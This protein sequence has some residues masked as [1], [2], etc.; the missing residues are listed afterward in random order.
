VG[1]SLVYL[2]ILA[3]VVG[4]VAL[5]K[6]L[7][8]L[9]IRNRR[10]AAAVLSFGLAL[11][12]AGALWPVSLKQS[13]RGD[14]QI[15]R[16]LP[17]YHF[18]ELHSIRVYAPPERILG[19]LK[20]VTI[21]EIRFARTLLWIRGLPGRLLGSAGPREV[22]TRPF[23]DVSDSPHSLILA[24]TEREI[25][26]G[27]VGRFWKMTPGGP[28]PQIENPQ[29]FRDF[30]AP[31]HARAAMNFYLEDQGA[32]WFRVTTETRVRAT[33]PSAAR[34]FAAYWRVIYPGSS[35][36]RVTFLQA[37]KRRAEAES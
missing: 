20:A 25:V 30:D 17:A 23:L 14:R 3:T 31:G 36:L 12:I 15:D 10:H 7:G 8:I 19:A 35:F 28:S 18:H 4:S 32:G 29:A 22:G 13:S 6:P 1:S 5:I 9:R 34:L 2:G 37:V 16:F 24:E 27:I 33:D 26:L 21:R 11:G